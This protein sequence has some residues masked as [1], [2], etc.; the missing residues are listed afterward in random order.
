MTPSASRRAGWMVEFPPRYPSSP[1]TKD[2]SRQRQKESKKEGKEEG[3]DPI[4][5][6]PS[7]PGLCPCSILPFLAI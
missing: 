6:A 2:G 7:A 3:Y 4:I 1:L 5:A